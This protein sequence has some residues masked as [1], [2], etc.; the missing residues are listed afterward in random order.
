L[1]TID[2]NELAGYEED[3]KGL[4]DF[5]RAYLFPS[6]LGL[7]VTLGGFFLVIAEMQASHLYRGQTPGFLQRVWLSF[8]SAAPGIGLHPPLQAYLPAALF[9][10]GLLFLAGTML[11]MARATPVSGV[12]GEKMEK[13]WNADA[14]P[15]V[16]EIIYVDRESHTYFRRVF[17]TSRARVIGQRRSGV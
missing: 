1:K 12:S 13:Y 6:L 8:E 15:G 4:R 9:V 5:Q 7:A 3:A 14:A 16:R 10:G 17:A 11:I 2:L